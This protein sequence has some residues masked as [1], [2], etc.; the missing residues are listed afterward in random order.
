MARAILPATTNKV[1]VTY[2]SRA[3]STAG[4]A[5][6]IGAALAEQGLVVDIRPMGEVSDLSPYRAI[7]AGSAIRRDK[8]LTEAMQFMG[9]HQAELKQKPFAAFLVCLALAKP[10]ERSRKS[11]SVWL[12]PVREIVHPMSEGLF[13]GVLDLGKLPLLYRIL[14]RPFML[15]TGI[16]EGDYRDWEAIRN[17][18]EQLPPKLL[19][20]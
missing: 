7:V 14:F 17:W 18:A 8:W 6:A 5:E 13:A 20:S 16:S 1:L 19:E 12:Q 4:I 3:G 10:N 15:L 9:Q 2:A 11:A